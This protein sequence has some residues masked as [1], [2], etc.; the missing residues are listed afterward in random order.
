MKTLRNL[1]DEWAT[2]RDELGRWI[3]FRNG[4]AD[5]FNFF[6]SQKDARD[7]IAAEKLRAKTCVYC[8][9]KKHTVQGDTCPQF[10]KE[11]NR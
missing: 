8:G 6:G 1:R 4:K 9:E 3:V 2:K 11:N 10:D 7:F 5:K